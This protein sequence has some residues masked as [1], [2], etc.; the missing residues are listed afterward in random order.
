[1]AG[2]GTVTWYDPNTKTFAA[3]GHG[4]TDV[5]TGALMPIRS[6]SILPTT[7]TGVEKGAKGAP[8]Q[9][10]G[11]FDL[12]LELGSLT[13]NSDSGVFGTLSETAWAGDPIPVAKRSQVQVGEAEILANISGNEVE[14]YQVEIKRIYPQGLSQG[15]DL[16]IE[17]TDPALLSTT[18][19]IVQ[20]MSG[21]PI[22][23]NGRLV[24]AVTHVLVN[25]PT[26]G[27]GI[28]AEEML[29]MVS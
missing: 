21:S 24:G 10:H 22:L 29:D 9:L 8:G 1:M 15:R 4:I 25:D 28:L 6:G 26:Q 5:D 2:I 12:T 3:L 19:G 16:L 27:Y 17:V 20:G 14:H 11:S 18:G 23:Q 7:V 13:V